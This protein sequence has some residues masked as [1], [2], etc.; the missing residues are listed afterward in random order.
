MIEKDFENYSETRQRAYSDS[1]RPL[2]YNTALSPIKE[3]SKHLPVKQ[4]RRRRRKQQVQN[5]F[6]IEK[7]ERKRKIPPNKEANR[8]EVQMDFIKQI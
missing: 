6:Q 7:V 4:T 2:A 1:L 8:P 5:V 3:E